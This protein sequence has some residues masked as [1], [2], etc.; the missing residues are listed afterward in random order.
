MEERKMKGK[1][2][3]SSKFIFN[4]NYGNRYVYYNC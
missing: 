2:V 1:R 4:F 3:V